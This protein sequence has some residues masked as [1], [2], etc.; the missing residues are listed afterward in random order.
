MKEY[1]T[2]KIALAKWRKSLRIKKILSWCTLIA[3]RNVDK[4]NS[5]TFMREGAIQMAKLKKS[6]I[7][8]SKIKIIHTLADGTVRDS[9]EG[10]EIPYNDT[11]TIA[12]QLLTKWTNEK[13]KDN[14]SA[15]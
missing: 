6:E 3:L 13:A 9:I 15:Q 7:D 10:Y 1:Q 2:D 11:T 12:Y 14:K 5:H 8:D 4:L